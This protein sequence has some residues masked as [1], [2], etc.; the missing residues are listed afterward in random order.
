MPER[1]FSLARSQGMEGS[2]GN[3]RQFAIDASNTTPIFKGDLVTLA[4]GYVV[5]SAGTAGTTVL[6]VFWGCEYV[7]ADGGIKFANRWNG[8]AGSSNIKAHVSLVGPASSLLV[9]VDE[10]D[11]YTVA[12]IGRLKPAA[13]GGGGSTLTGQSSMKLGA[14]GA[15]VATA[16]LIVTQFFDANM[17]EV[18]PAAAGDAHFA[19]VVVANANLV[20][21]VGL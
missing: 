2:T 6:G 8:V 4:G 7:D 15:S 13:A 9:G 12:D 17:L 1:G 21:G 18:I 19:E 16:P 3:L 10:T 5:G 20:L 11:T 14:A